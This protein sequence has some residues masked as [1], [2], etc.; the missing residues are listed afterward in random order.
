MIREV[1]I[2]DNL[3]VNMLIDIN[4]QN[5]EGMIID[6]FQRKLIIASCADFI[7]AIK[8]FNFGKRVNKVI[9]NK[10]QISL[11]S[12]LI[13]NVFIQLRDNIELSINRDYMFHFETFFDLSSESG[14][15]THI[16]DANIS[17]IQIRNVTHRTTII[18]RY[19]KLKRIMNYEKKECYLTFS[20]NAH[21]A[22]KPKKQVF[23]KFF[24][25]TLIGLVTVAMFTDVDNSPSPASLAISEIASKPTTSVMKAVIFRGI[26]IYGDKAI[27]VKLKAVIDRFF[28]L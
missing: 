21:L 26:T 12:Q 27:R 10:R 8:V 25:L 1:H 7:T 22:I 5:F 17:I 13:I 16:V 3:R 11:S 14:V 20:K 24:K 28:E 18:S 2:V 15:F 19:A 23:K 4:I 9:R 6:I